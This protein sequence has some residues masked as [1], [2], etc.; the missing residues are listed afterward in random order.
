LN[1]EVNQEDIRVESIN[2]EGKADN[3]TPSNL[4]NRVL[5]D[6]KGDFPREDDTSYQVIPTDPEQKRQDAFRQ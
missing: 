6:Y 3:E 5:D 2:E 1:N 4:G